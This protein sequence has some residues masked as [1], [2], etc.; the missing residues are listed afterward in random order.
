[1]VPG[2]GSVSTVAQ[3]EALLDKVIDPCS[4]GLGR[5]AGLVTMGLVKSLTLTEAA[6]GRKRLD[7]LLRLTSPCCMMGPY[8]AERAKAELQQLSEL[9]AIEVR[10]CPQIDWEPAHMR[11][12][13][14]A[15][16]AGQ[17][18]PPKPGRSA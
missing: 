16:L 5:P 12:E 8:F 10:I 6:N 11:P 13:Y 7:V 17:R 4:A 15:R 9:A 3:I 1:M 14:R 2:A 18:R